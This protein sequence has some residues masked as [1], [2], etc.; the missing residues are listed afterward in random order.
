MP[1]VKVTRNSQITIPKEIRDR[2]G[3]K[4]GDRVDI[5]IEGDKVVVRKVE[6]EDITDFLPKNFDEIRAKMRKDSRK[7][8]KKLG[9]IP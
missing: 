4:E 6:L 1:V 9:V 8:L 2:I 3:I 5:S 7:R